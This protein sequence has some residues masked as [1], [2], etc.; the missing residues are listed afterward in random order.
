MPGEVIV[1]KVVD[2]VIGW[3]VGWDWVRQYFVVVAISSAVMD[4]CKGAWHGKSQSSSCLQWCGVQ[5]IGCGGG[6]ECGLRRS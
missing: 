2:P 4:I 1:L 3:R 5:K 6:G